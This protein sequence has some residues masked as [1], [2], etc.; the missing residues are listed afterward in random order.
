M[1]CTK[2][3]KE[4]D[5]AE[6]HKGKYVCKKCLKKKRFYVT[7]LDRN[8]KQSLGYFIKHKKRCFWLNILGYKREEF[9]KHLEEQFTGDMNWEN[10]GKVWGLT[11]F[12]PRRCYN[13][14]NMRDGEFSKLYSLKNLKVDTL[15]NCFR[16]KSE[17]DINCL[18]KRGLFDILPL[19]NLRKMIDLEKLMEEKMFYDFECE[20]GN[21]ETISRSMK[22]CSLPAT[23]SLCGK[24]MTRIYNA[25]DII[26]KGSGFSKSKG[27]AERVEKITEK[28]LVGNKYAKR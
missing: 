14:K 23:C 25:A 18:T 13:I 17:I 10:Y 8:I 11:F 1:I 9:F 26:F 7:T 5:L 19:G 27:S 6:F 3:H 21:K 28:K 20:C 15:I 2:C 12:I 22:D 16:Q 24:E 4:K